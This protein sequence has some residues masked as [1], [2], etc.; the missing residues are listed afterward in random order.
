MKKSNTGYIAF[1]YTE[2]GK[3]N[4]PGKSL[5]IVV[6]HFNFLLEC[7]GKLEIS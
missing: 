6:Y 4:T 5:A 3:A 7:L 2:V 1:K